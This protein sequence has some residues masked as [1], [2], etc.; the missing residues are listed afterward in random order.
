MIPSLFIRDIQL[1][2]NRLEV[3]KNLFLDKFLAYHE[4]SR[5]ELKI[6]KLIPK[7]KP[8]YIRDLAK[9]ANYDHSNASRLVKN[10]TAKGLV[11]TSV[12]PFDKRSK[13]VR[14]S[15]Q[16][17]DLLEKFDEALLHRLGEFIVNY[18]TD[19]LSN[20]IDTLADL[21]LYLDGEKEAA[22]V[23]RKLRKK[24]KPSVN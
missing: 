22:M 16:G 11:I 15:A 8:C 19:K 2:L 24:A 6:L 3:Y 4:I 7:H 10:L 1:N 23:N 14:L 5:S 18:Q 13:Q 20:L 12:P 17:R 21:N 9:E